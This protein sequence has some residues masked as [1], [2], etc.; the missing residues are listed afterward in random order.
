MAL[1]KGFALVVILCL[2]TGIGVNA[3]L[4]SVVDGVLIQPFPYDDP[5]RLVVLHNT[6]PASNVQF[7]RFSWPDIRDMVETQRAFSTLAFLSFRSFTLVDTSDPERYQGAAVSWNL[8]SM[9]GVRPALGRD[10]AAGDDVAGAAGVVL[11]SDEIWR[12]RYQSDPAVLT[13]RV[14]V[15]GLPHDVIG[16]MPPGFKFPQN[17]Q[18]WVPVT[19]LVH[20]DSRGTRT[21]RPYARLAPGVTLA[22]ANEEVRAI[23][24]QLATQHPGTNKGWVARVITLRDEFIPDDVTLSLWLMMGAATLV[25][26]IACSNAANLLLA[27]ATVRRREISVRAALGAG[28]GRIVRQ[29]LTESALFGILSVPLGLAIAYAG[30]QLLAASIPPDEVPYYIT[31]AIDWRSIGYAVIVA[32]GTTVVFGLVPALHATRGT[33]HDE[34]KEGT[35]GN[36]GARSWARN[37]LVVAQL[38]L[39][40]VS[41]VGAA[42]FVRTFINMNDYDVGFDPAPLVTLRVFYSGEEFA[43]EGAMG[44]TTRDLVER[45]ERLPGVRSVFASNL[46]PLDGGGGGGRLQIDGVTYEPG[47]EPDVAYVGVTPGFVRTL[48]MTIVAGD[49]MTESQGWG[50]SEVAL[51]NRTLV[52]RFFPDGNPLG[53]RIRVTQGSGDAPWFTIIGVV[54]DVRHYVDTNNPQEPVVYVP[55]GWQDMANTGFTINVDGDPSAAGPALR[56]E[57]RAAAPSIPIF[58]IQTMEELRRLSFWQFAIFGW[59][60]GLI[61]AVALLLA[62]VG[63]FGVLSYSVSQRT[64]E[65]GVRLALG[66]SQASIR[67]LVLQQGLLLAG[68]GVVVGLV[69]AALVTSNAVSLLYNVTPTDPLSFAAVG[70]FLMLMAAVA[71]YVPARRAMRV[72]P[73]EALRGE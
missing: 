42:L 17:Q 66:S 34:L 20:Q 9:V 16:V 11:I 73:I 65:I 51:V 43:P 40:V 12:L 50:R 1:Q 64:R 37:V 22:Q 57:V 36:S 48:G 26:F 45:F 28:R 71:S 58:A 70:M 54:S 52:S 4:F 38:A 14:L 31:W 30:T 25:L 2:G 67:T 63:V 53:R 47:R 21:L 7:A 33:L 5:E 13:R 72:N 44:R 23:T 41:L 8:F 55:H 39:A 69:A 59:V 19:P 29:L 68:T 6:Q 62:T 61:G 15:N 56:R 24:Q 35:R 49:N 27:R 3:T 10:F 32:V 18:L 46:V 60:F